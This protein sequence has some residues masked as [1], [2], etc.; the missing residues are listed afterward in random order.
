M[1]ASFLRSQYDFSE[2]IKV[3]KVDFDAMVKLDPECYY[4]EREGI[5]ITRNAKFSVSVSVVNPKIML[6]KAQ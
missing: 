5:L 6:V 3:N 2:L 4:N 1:N